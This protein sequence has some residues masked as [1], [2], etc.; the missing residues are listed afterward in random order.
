MPVTAKVRWVALVVASLL[1]SA[2]VGVVGVVEVVGAQERVS[3]DLEEVPAKAA[4]EALGEEAGA[5]FVLQEGAWEQARDVSVTLPSSTFWQAFVL[6]GRW[7][8]IE[9][10]FAP[11]EPRPEAVGDDEAPALRLRRVDLGAEELPRPTMAAGPLLVRP[12]GLEVLRTPEQ[13][14]V[15]LEPAQVAIA[16]ELFV[17]PRVAWVG[18][19]TGRTAVYA[20]AAGLR[21]EGTINNVRGEPVTLLLRR[22]GE[23]DPTISLKGGVGRLLLAFDADV[24]A[25]GVI[26]AAIPAWRGLL[27]VVYAEDWHTHRHPLT[28]GEGEAEAL[29]IV[30]TQFITVSPLQ[31]GE[32]AEDESTP[33]RATIALQVHRDRPD[34]G[35]V[36]L[37]EWMRLY[38]F[39]QSIP[40]TLVGPDGEAWARRGYIVAGELDETAG[41]NGRPNPLLARSYR[42][43]A[44]YV[45]PADAERK[46]EANFELVWTLPTQ[47]SEERVPIVWTAREPDE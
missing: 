34:A 22:A 13:A 29:P 15:T 8:G 26:P 37:T 47:A 44:S 5:A 45:E 36:P 17:E 7:A 10:V 4:F 33:R 14:R 2:V 16:A 28:V 11:L 21:A 24:R 32:P 43:W 3:L 12:A 46:A 31:L 39:L 20:T 40:P 41:P 25:P 38:H 42:V 27:R 9:P 18:E 6:L 23:Y 19:P 1:C 30:G 35:P